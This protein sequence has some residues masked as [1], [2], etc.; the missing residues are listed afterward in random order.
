M[1]NKCKYGVATCP[2]NDGD[3]CNY[4]GENPMTPPMENNKGTAPA[5]PQERSC[6]AIHFG[7]G[8]VKAPHGA[9]VMHTS[10]LPD[11]RRFHWLEG[12]PDRP[13]ASV[14][15]PSQTPQ[16]EDIPWPTDDEAKQALSAFKSMAHIY[17]YPTSSP[18]PAPQPTAPDSLPPMDESIV[19]ALEELKEHLT[20]VPLP[21]MAVRKMV[22]N[23]VLC[24]ILERERQLLAAQQ[25]IAE[26][27]RKPVVG[28]DKFDELYERSKDD[29][30][31]IVGSEVRE[32]IGAYRHAMDGVGYWKRRGLF[33][34]GKNPADMEQGCGKEFDSDAMFRCAD[35]AIP[36]CKR[37]IFTHF[38]EE[39]KSIRVELSTLRAQLAQKA[40]GFDA[41]L[42]SDRI[43]ELSAMGFVDIARAAWIASSP[44]QPWVAVSERL[45]ELDAENCCMEPDEFGHYSDPV[46]VYDE[47]RCDVL[48]GAYDAKKFRWNEVHCGEHL[49][50]VTH[51]QPL[52]AP[53]VTEPKKEM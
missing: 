53:P 4:E 14:A 21:V 28:M 22:A 46:L 9:E 44:A 12:T 6:D 43:E 8:C 41:W 10:W 26:F 32:V 23:N 2:C 18:I 29:Q 5:E 20:A 45:P 33:I 13:L 15:P 25:R 24:A 27:S 39:D 51:W 47:G 17:L 7:Q 30:A 38:T 31:I 34:C 40:E 36:F 48:V 42:T 11:G 3:P 50:D 19:L 37:C 35:C 49:E 1:E 16:E 52:P